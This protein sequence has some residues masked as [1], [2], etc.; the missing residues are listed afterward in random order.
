MNKKTISSSKLRK[1]LFIYLMIALLILFTLL[2]ASIILPIYD[3]LK[4]SENRNLVHSVEMKAVAISEWGRRVKN[5]ALQITSRTR[6]RQELEKYNDSEISL[7]VVQSFTTPKL[8]DAMNLSN[9]VIGII[10][11]DKKNRTVAECGIIIQ[12]SKWPEL[13]FT[14]R[15]TTISA[16]IEVQDRLV[17]IIGAQIQN[18]INEVV[19]TDLVVIDMKY[20]KAIID[21]SSMLGNDS[22]IILGSLFNNQIH[23][24]FPLKSKNNKTQKIRALDSKEQ[25]TLQAAIQ[26]EKGIEQLNK[27]V[28]AY[29]PIKGWNWGLLIT[30]NK[31]ELYSSL[32][33]ILTMIIL[34]SFIIYIACLFGFWLMMK[35][36]SVRILLNT[37]ELEAVIREK[38][39]SL[40]KAN[41]IINRSSSVAFL[42]KND[43]GLTVAFV[44]E[45]VTDLLGYSPDDLIAGNIQYTKFIHP[46]DK[47]RVLNE[48]EQFNILNAQNCFEMEP[49]KITTKNNQVKWISG[50]IQVI[51]NNN[52]DIIQY[53]GV[54]SDITE[55]KQAEEQIKANLKEKETLLLN[56]QISKERYQAVAD[57]TYDWETWLDPDGNYVYVSPSCERISGYKAEEFINDPDL[58][59]K[60]AVPDD[61]EIVAKHFKEHEKLLSKMQPFDFRITKKNGDTIWI[62]HACQSVFDANGNDL[63]KR[64]SN[65]EITDRKV[66]EEQIKAL[67]QEKELLLKEVHHRIRNNMSTIKSLLSL[68]SGTLNNAEAKMALKEAENR[69]ESMLVLYDKLFLSS[70]LQNVSTKQ[71]FE[72]LIDEIIKN[73]PNK[74]IVSVTYEI[75]DVMLG[76]KIIFDLGIIINELITNTMKHAFVG[77]ESGKINASLVVDE[78]HAI[79]TIQDD[80]IELPESVSFENPAAGFGFKLVFMLVKQLDGS[81]EIERKEGTKFTIKFNIET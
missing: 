53:E 58:M 17:I 47:E 31:D 60:I 38:T 15:N 44:S 24:I 51:R 16:P 34:I 28:M 42:W 21:E 32:N 62:S 14:K 8:I 46:D 29:Y 67:L 13:D 40:E 5:V 73:F 11:L 43:E 74:D 59:N 78:G 49:Y 54:L 81:I 66:A 64:G 65:R 36:L 33:M 63:G 3:R 27:K 75:K 35:P 39:I 2:S 61:K 1:D 77:K 56:I 22:E 45:N 10:R 48:I 25:T 7:N 6:I 30:Q 68:Q 12:K 37:E 69:V 50:N 52:S 4:E 72:T 41:S 71:Y 70:D 18:R 23:S 55:R 76:A 9:E 20:L 26:G 79:M 80:G 19:G 57:F